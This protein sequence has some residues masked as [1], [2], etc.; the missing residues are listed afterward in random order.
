MIHRHPQAE[1]QSPPQSPT[2]RRFEVRAYRPGDE[3]RI[4]E[5]FN[6]VFRDAC[7]PSF[8][9]RTMD[10]WTWQYLD[11]PEGTRIMLAVGADGTVAGHYAGVPVLADTPW[12]C[13]RFVHCVDS[14]THPDWQEGLPPPGLF[15]RTGAAF[16]E[17]C[18][19]LGEG[20]CYGFPIDSAFQIGRRHLG[21]EMMCAIDYLVRD[22]RQP[23]LQADGGV[24]V[25][26][27]LHLPADIDPLYD[28]VL[29]EKRCM[30]RRDHRYL[31]WRY[32]ANPNRGAYEVWTAWR[33][34]RLRGLLVLRPRHDLVPDA[35]TVV[36]LL[37]SETDPSV[38]QALLAA[39]VHR[40]H[41]LGR[42][43]LLAVF[44]QWS[45]EHA[46]FERLGFERTPSARWLQ[47]RLVHA[48]HSAHLTP[49][50]LATH[51]WFTLGDSDLV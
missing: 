28:A 23:P 9:D 32:L 46:L 34:D 50:F 21:Y 18:L 49:H 4:L 45:F 7:G 43:R 15:A 20:L 25:R 2:S 33:G 37:V 12:G 48:V 29:A 35:M 19:R 39:A 31:H 1:L 30:V 16:G 5:T 24:E 17:Q 22:L 47:R 36:E 6:R 51:W 41:D 10:Q 8:V 40:Q 26:R 14:M 42:S 3:N 44:P 38:T 13:M 11:N 27:A